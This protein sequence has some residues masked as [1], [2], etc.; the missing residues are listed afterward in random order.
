MWSPAEFFGSRWAEPQKGIPIIV[1]RQGEQVFLL[2]VQPPSHGENEELQSMGHPPRL[3]ARVSAVQKGR[4]AGARRLYSRDDSVVRFLAPYEVVYA[5]EEGLGETTVGFR[6]AACSSDPPGFSLIVPTRGRP[7]QLASCLD[8]LCGLDYPTTHYEII[9]VDDGAGVEL[10]ERTGGPGAD[11]RVLRQKW[12]G[13][14]VARN[15]GARAARFEY[16]AFI[17]DDCRATPNWLRV[18]AET[19]LLRND[20]L[21]GGRVVNALVNNAYAESSQFLIDYLS[22]Y[23]GDRRGRFFTSN[24]IAVSRANFRSVGGF[25]DS[26]CLAAGEDRELSD[27]WAAQGRPMLFVDE[28]VVDHYHD[29]SLSDFSSQHFGYGRGA[30]N[31]HRVRLRR[32]EQGLAVESAR[33]YLGM[34]RYPFR[35]KD[36]LHGFVPATLIACSQ[37]LNALGFAWQRSRGARYGRD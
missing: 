32:G 4:T 26:F 6:S 28:A 15:H 36:L 17:D 22:E 25:D 20:V 8:S 18:L 5:P 30:W 24:N 37:V 27:R 9:V 7:I 31:Y 21:I 29:L 3:R 33:F 14:A 35:K 12:S 13:P 23:Y 1:E 16:L 11:L 34:L 2:A 19:F 10:E